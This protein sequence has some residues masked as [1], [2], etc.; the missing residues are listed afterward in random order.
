[1]TGFYQ[2]AIRV[3]RFLMPIWYHIETEGLENVPQN[4]GYLFISNH[5]SNADPILIGIQNP[6]TQFC[7]LA[8]QELFADGMVGWLLH[9]LGAV[10]V[11]R[12]SGDITPLEEIMDR[13]ENGDNALIFPEGTRSADGKLGRF[14]SGAALIAAQTGV[15][16]VPVAIYFEDRLR[17]RSCISVR[18]GKPFDIPK[19][20]PENPSGS[21]LKNIRKAMTEQV[22]ALLPEA[23]AAARIPAK[24]AAAVLPDAAMETTTPEIKKSEDREVV[25]SKNK[26]NNN[27]PQDPMPEKEL[28]AG[29]EDLESVESI[30]GGEADPP[31]EK[32]YGSV[33]KKPYSGPPAKKASPFKMK[34]PFRK[35]LDGD[36]FPEPPDEEEIA[37]AP[38]PA[39]TPVS[40]ELEPVLE[41]DGEEPVAEPVMEEEPPEEIYDEGYAD[42]VPAEEP[43]A[44]EPIDEEPVEPDGPSVGGFRLHNPF[45]KKPAAETDEEFPDEDEGYF[46]GADDEEVV[47]DE[48][49]SIDYGKIALILTFVILG[50][51]AVDFCRRVYNDFAGKN[52][53]LN[54]QTG[55][56]S[57]VDSM[58]PEVTE[59]APAITT[60]STAAAVITDKVQASTSVTI[61]TTTMPSDSTDTTKTETTVNRTGETVSVSNEDVK[62]GSLILLDGS[63]TLQS[64]PA[65]VKFNAIEGFREKSHL[66]LVSAENVIDSSMSQPLMSW[67]GDFFNATG[68]GNVMIYATTQ[69]PAYP[70]YNVTIPERASGL[71][72]DLSLLSNDGNSHAPFTA[73]GNY[74]W[75]LEHASDYGFIQRYPNDKVDKTGME[76]LSWHFRYVGAPHAAYMKAN[77]LCLEE[78]LDTVRT[79][80]WKGEHLTSTAAGINYEIYY[81]PA[82]ETS[83]TTDIPFPAGATPIISGNNDDGFVVAVVKQ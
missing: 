63:H 16:V 75:V 13:L 79:H 39:E 37:P 35:F 24:P 68:M 54:I 65:V 8:K 17:F 23:Q 30:L 71:S 47:Y 82:S 44:E 77:G 6:E 18:Y 48:K 7:F 73:D 43:V 25:M 78:Y 15:P 53:D 51:F 55:E 26:R 20:D 61:L 83:P 29:G 64:F 62:K 32:K 38:L 11:D 81:V 72:L 66:R 4:G 12:G 60:E 56:S 2:F 76:G 67:F 50:I 19:M 9:K 5:R 14:K 70:P 27:K 10:A 3:M 46:D 52:G 49:R 69:D 42:E 41:Y 57:E 74:A 33:E 36:D 45:G 31:A 40:D 28:R 22:S 59:E 34:N 80:T 21:V 58:N 1:M